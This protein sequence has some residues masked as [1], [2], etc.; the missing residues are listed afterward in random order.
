[1]SVTATRF[2]SAQDAPRFGEGFS[3]TATA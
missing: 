3:V 2:Y 1:V